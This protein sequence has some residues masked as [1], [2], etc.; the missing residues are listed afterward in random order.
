MGTATRT[1]FL[2]LL[3]LTLVAAIVTPSQNADTVAKKPVPIKFAELGATESCEFREGVR[4]F[5]VE[6]SNRPRYQGYIITYGTNHE[7]ARRERLITNEVAYRKYDRSRVTLV[8]GGFKSVPATELWVI[9]PGADNPVPSGGDEDPPQSSVVS[10]PFTVR[11]FGYVIEEFVLDSVRRKEKVNQADSSQMSR[12]SGEFDDESSD[13]EP[14]AWYDTP[15]FDWVAVIADDVAATADTTGVMIFYADD[16]RYDIS[17]LTK[18][19][20][21]ARD[22]LI[23]EAKIKRT[24]LQVQFGGYREDAEVEYWLIP[25]SGTPPE[26]HPDERCK[27]ES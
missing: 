14:R 9:P 20:A 8:R 11:R 2:T 17:R 5:M 18:F 22:R 21:K 6:L 15:R 1:R 10:E 25:S 13:T 16:R 3:V 7:I 12:S 26:P 23:A 19:V 27:D 4:R 24:R